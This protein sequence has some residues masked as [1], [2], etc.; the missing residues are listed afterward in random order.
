MSK[1]TRLVA[2]ALVAAVPVVGLVAAP[3]GANTRSSTP[4]KTVSPQQWATKFCT[5]LGD[6]ENS[7]SNSQG[8]LQSAASGTDLVA[9][10]TA[11][12][13]FL[14]QAIDNT[15]TAIADVKA[16]G[17]PNVTNGKKISDAIVKALRKA[18]AIFVKAEADA[19]ALSTADATTFGTDVQAIG[20]QITSSGSEI[21]AGFSS[22]NKLD[23]GGKLGK[24]V[25]S[26]RACAFLKTSA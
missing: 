8:D 12:V 13:D 5:A 20:Q 10:K 21:D 15:D 24:V 1:L 16:A 19:E 23:K 11:L 7:I 22:L 17:T 9:T 26:S 6:W 14:S 18:K 25:K 4:A 3:A 2:I